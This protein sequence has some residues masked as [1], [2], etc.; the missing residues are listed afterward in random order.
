MAWLKVGDEAATYPAF[1]R[2]DEHNDWDERLTNEMFGFLARCATQAAAHYTDYIVSLG[3]A[4]LIAGGRATELLQIA[5]D[6]E[7]AIPVD[8]D[9]RRQWKL[10]DD[11]KFM[12]MRSKEE[13]DRDNQRKRDLSDHDLVMPVRIRDGDQCRYCRL[14]VNWGD[15]RGARGGTYDHRN[16]INGQANPGNVV[17]CCRACNRDRGDDP[18]ADRRIPL[19]EPPALPYYKKRTA[20]WINESPW[21][22][23]HGTTVTA[24]S[25]KP[26]GTTGRQRPATQAGHAPTTPHNSGTAHHG[27]SDPEPGIARD[28]DSD[29][30]WGI[31]HRGDSDRAP[32]TARPTGDSDREKTVTAAP[33]PSGTSERQP[34]APPDPP[35]NSPPLTNPDQS[36]PMQGTT[37]PGIPGSGRDGS[38]RGGTARVGNPIPPPTGDGPSENSPAAGRRSRGRRRK[39]KT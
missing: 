35:P 33:T 28:S 13:V 23:T 31:A 16:G 7:L 2:V 30:P 32:G 11:E 29:R 38:G 17:V 36:W 26:S 24:S 27:D 8:I 21:A 37:E 9:G 14:V 19:L 39:R 10:I 20:E 25:S 22:K 34:T 6:C 4:R 18:D 15:Q 3:T 5:V 1:L 12:H